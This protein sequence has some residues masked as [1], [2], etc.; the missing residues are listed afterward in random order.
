MREHIALYGNVAILRGICHKC[1]RTALVID[2]EYQCC[3]SK[4]EENSHP[5]V[6]RMIE[7]EQKRR[8]SKKKEQQKTLIEQENRCLYCSRKFGSFV[9]RGS[10]F[11]VVRLCWDHL[12]PYSYNQDN[13]HHNFVAACQICNRIK[14][15][16]MFQTVDEARVHIMAV[17]RIKGIMV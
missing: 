5:E 3:G 9:K 14:H 1:K 6:K 2:G 11:V 7:C 15:S 17:R 13:G 4:A 8:R 16:F 10:R 12:V